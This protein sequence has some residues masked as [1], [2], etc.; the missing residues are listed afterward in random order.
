MP[1][2]VTLFT[3]QWADLP[4]ETLA[5]KAKSWG[6]DGLELC[7]WGDH[8]D[9]LRAAEDRAYAQEQ[10]ELL[11]QHGLEA[12]AFSVHL[13]G[14]LTLDEPLDERHAIIYH[15]PAEDRGK[16]EAMRKWAVD[17]CMAAPRAAKNLGVE[18]VTGFT[19]SSI[20]H[21]WFPFPPQVASQIEAGYRRFAEVWNPIM[22]EFGRHGVRFGLEVHPSEIAFDFHSSQQT[23]DAIGRRPEF[24]FNF[25]PSHLVWQGVDPVRFVYQFADRIYHVHVKDSK[26][27]LNGENSL[28][29]SNLNFGDRRRGWDFISPGHGDVDFEAIFRALNRIGY[30]GPLSVEW[31]DNAMD[32][33]YGAPEALQM[34]RRLDFPTSERAFDDAF[35]QA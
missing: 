7:S 30:Q 14:Q 2:P 8:F 4:L 5:Q 13:A 26:R 11:K 3:G 6:Y 16:P 1:R 24:G 35:K 31:E 9:V 33:E 18:V 15:G 32:R 10:R 20:W 22:D 25:D 23:L 29:T 34:V 12:Y 17:L 19:G 28:L 27:F 21:L